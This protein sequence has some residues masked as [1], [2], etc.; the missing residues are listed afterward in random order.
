MHWKHEQLAQM[1]A[2]VQQH[3]PALGKTKPNKPKSQKTKKKTGRVVDSWVP[4]GWGLVGP[5][6][7]NETARD[8]R[9]SAGK[10]L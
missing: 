1:C 3:S 8:F 5:L 2:S 4:R 7:E 10:G 6:T 9:L